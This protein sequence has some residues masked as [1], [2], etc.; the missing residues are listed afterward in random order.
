MRTI[1][2]LQPNT[3]AQITAEKIIHYNSDLRTR[4]DEIRYGLEWILSGVN[5]LLVVLILTIPFGV[6]KE[7]II[8]LL[9]G[10]ILRMFSGGAHLKGYFRCLL[11]SS[12]Q[13][14]TISFISKHFYEV[15]SQNVNLMHLF[16][17]ISLTIVCFKAPILN[18]KSNSFSRRQRHQLKGISIAMFICLLMVGV[19]WGSTVE[20]FV[21]WFSLL[22]QT[23]TLTSFG[24]NLFAFIDKIIPDRQATITGK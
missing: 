13:I 18:K 12:I 23:L 9:T 2:F 19:I 14:F 4:K 22:V 8:A 15:I 21:I 7:G 11:L 17:G 3:I 16:L 24:K 6:F 20:T 10:A 5:Q 1:N